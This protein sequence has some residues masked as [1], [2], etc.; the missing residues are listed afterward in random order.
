MN[1]DV[2]VKRLSGRRFGYSHLIG[3]V[4]IGLAVGIAATR[5]HR[6]SYNECVVREI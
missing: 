6:E 3:A 1:D 2:I 5:F 4:I